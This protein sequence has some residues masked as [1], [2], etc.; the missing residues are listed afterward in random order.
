MDAQGTHTQGTHQ[1]VLDD[2]ERVTI[3]GTGTMGPSIAAA[4]ATA[5]IDVT[6]WGRRT[7]SVTQAVEAAHDATTWLHREGLSVDR[8][9]RVEG[10]E[11]LE[12]AVADAVLA[13]EA[14]SEDTA[15]KRELYA[16]VEAAAPTSM[17]LASTTSGLGPDQLAADCRHP[18]R[19]LVLHFWNPAHLIPLVEVLG[20]EHTDP[21]LVAQASE[22]LRSMGKYPVELHRFVP[23]FIG[24]RLQQAVVREAI[25]LFEAGVAD[26][27]DIDAATRL[28]FGARFPVM[29]PLET[30][31]L[32]GLDVVAAIHDYLLAELDTS[33]APQP[34]LTE[35]VER[36]E[37]GAKSGRGFY[38]WS[39]RDAG[40][41]S[42]ERDRELLDRIHRLRA[43]GRLDAPSAGG[44]R[45]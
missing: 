1:Q 23:G 12:Q 36:G 8:P 38:D 44:G 21:Q 35:R 18:E 17:V 24:T 30:C 16:R 40:S 34:A 43:D 6:L 32:G 9:G 42:S 37:L 4:F 20:G 5:G 2:V 10:S 29:G 33:G 31:D 14:V 7:E 26:A 25:A 28:S 11:H 3:L 13:V 39:Q 15:V 45:G 41:L 19:F 22:L 27:A